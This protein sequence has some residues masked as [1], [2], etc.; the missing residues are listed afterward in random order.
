M[1]ELKNLLASFDMCQHVQD[2]SYIAGGCLYLVIA[3]SEVKVTNSL[4]SNIGFSNHCLVTCQLLANLSDG[5][6]FQ[7][8]V[9]HGRGFQLRVSSQTCLN[10][11]YVA[12]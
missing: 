9:V 8:K 7:F 3:Q 4:V 1:D 5:D 12:I 2:A 6:P 11:H 10:Q